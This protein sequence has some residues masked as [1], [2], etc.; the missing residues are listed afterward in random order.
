MALVR[1][2]A[3][4]SLRR[5][6]D[7][8][9]YRDALGQILDEAKRMTGIIESLLT[10]ARVDSGA[11]TLHV[12]T[13]DVA[14]LARDACSRSEALAESKQIAFEREIPEASILVSGDASAL[15]RL[16]VIVIDNAIKYTPAQGRVRVSVKASLTRSS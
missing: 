15:Q 1:T 6:R 9:E 12:R 16:F 5:Q 4:L 3:E 10:L 11:E 14:S 7:N 8:P 2:T 13:V